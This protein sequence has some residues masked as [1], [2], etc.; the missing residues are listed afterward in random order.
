M[1]NR[2]SFLDL[3][4][5]LIDHVRSYL[6][7]KSRTRLFLTC[8]KILLLRESLKISAP[9][10]APQTNFDVLARLIR[11][12]PNVKR[13][14]FGSQSRKKDSQ[15]SECF[16]RPL[17]DLFKNNYPPH[18]SA[19]S[20]HEIKQSGASCYEGGDLIEEEHINYEFLEALCRPQI[21]SLELIGWRNISS[22]QLD[23]VSER[24]GNLKTFSANLP[25][26]PRPNKIGKF[27]FSGRIIDQAF[28]E[29]LRQMRCLG[30]LILTARESQP[31]PHLGEFLCSKHGLE[32]NVL[33]LGW[34]CCLTTD[35]ALIQATEQLPCLTFFSQVGD[36]S[37]TDRGLIQFAMNCP[38]LS[39]CKFSPYEISDQGL[40]VFSQKTPHL[41][42]LSL[43]SMNRITLQGIEDFLRHKPDLV[44]LEL[45]WQLEGEVDF[46][47]LFSLI[48]KY[49]KKLEYFALFY[50]STENPTE[51]LIEFVRCCKNLKYLETDNTSGL[52]DLTETF[53]NLRVNQHK[54]NKLFFRGL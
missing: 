21:T 44:A 49:C 27:I 16:I 22:R 51:Y 14:S 41:T 12:C 35:E 8:H 48:A 37:I 9:L 43:L 50:G 32:L 34:N 4:P 40:E 25:F 1:T 13:I 33:Q 6:D 52:T 17:I 45:S 30:K 28:I 23:L 18:L 5:P 19:L 38:L 29:S 11:R 53:P 46:A 3:L 24:C 39:I 47:S 10:Q 26:P 20:I 42:Q 31:S 15:Q 36:N 7:P 2:L 54:T